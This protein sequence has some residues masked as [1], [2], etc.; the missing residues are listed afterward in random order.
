[1]QHWFTYPNINPIAIHLGPI[2][3]H[4]YGISYLVGFIAVYLWMSRPAGRKRLGLTREQIQDF[5]VYALVGVLVGGRTFFVINDMI[6]KHDAGIYFHNPI[7]F[8]AVWN[9]GMAFHGG[10]VGVIIALFLFLRKHP[11]LTYKV[12]GDEVVV[13]L[14]VGIALTRV[15]N[16]I[17]DE[18]WG[19]ICKPD[20][21]WCMQPGANADV[22]ASMQGQFLH[23][24]QLYEAIL[25]A[26]TLPIVLFIYKKRPPDGVVA[27]SWFTMYGITR[28]VAENWRH[29]DF[30]WHGITGGQLYALPMIPIGLVGLYFCWRGR[31]RTD[32][33]GGDQA[34]VRVSTPTTTTGG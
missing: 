21:P 5:L 23:P 28:T 2:N 25:D 18:L 8:I 3:V 27:W 6:S 12:L 29:A 24:S 19:D 9:G 16:F 26:I 22:P 17:N 31:T 13:L 33:R 34:A 10:L 1:M 4:W 7:N 15:V 32:A 20:H 14:P 11:G 30:V